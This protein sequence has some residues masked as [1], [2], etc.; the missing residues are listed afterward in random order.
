MIEFGHQRPQNSEHCSRLLAF[1]QEVVAVCNELGITPVLSGSLA[2][3]AYTQ[4]PAISVN[5]IDLACSELDFPRL[6]R[7]LAAKGFRYELK[8]WHVLQVHSGDLKVEFDSIERWL[9][10]LPQ[11]YETLIIGECTFQ[12][13]ALSS[14]KE[15]YR[16]GLAGTA[17]QSDENNRAKY[18]AIAKKYELLCLV[19]RQAENAVRAA[20]RPAPRGS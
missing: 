2:V 19:E 17:T 4:S 13:V 7:A 9:R 11:A 1:C 15:L 18:L 16:R 20:A 3:F 5:D 14:L 12:V 6:S 8:T 10:D